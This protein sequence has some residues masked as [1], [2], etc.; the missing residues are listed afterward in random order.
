[1]VSPKFSKIWAL[2]NTE[3]KKIRIGTFK[4]SFTLNNVPYTTTFVYILSIA[5]KIMKPEQ[6]QESS[7]QTLK[8]MAQQQQH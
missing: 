8:T 7:L 1:M 2:L 5:H 6:Q 4:I 3:I